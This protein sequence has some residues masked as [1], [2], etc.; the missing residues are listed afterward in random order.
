MSSR[1]RTSYQKGHSSSSVSSSSSP[2]SLSPSSARSPSSSR[3]YNDN[4]SVVSGYSSLSVT[5]S[6]RHAHLPF[7][8]TTPTAPKPVLL[9]DDKHT[10]K[11]RGSVGMMIVGLSGATGCSLLASVVANRNKIQWRG[12]R[13]EWRS[14]N[15]NGCL[16]QINQRGKHGGVGYKDKIGNLANASM[17]AIGGWDIQTRKP[18]DSLLQAH[19]LDYDLVRQVKDDMNKIK[20]FRGIYDPRF[21]NSSYYDKAAHILSVDEVPN[22]SEALKCLR[23]DIRYFK[24]RNGVIGHTSIIWCASIEPDCA[25]LE[26]FKTARD[27]LKAIE[28][29]EEERGGPM[30]PSILYATAALLEGCS[31]I[32]GGNQN[33]LSCAGLSDLAIQLRGVFCLGTGF[34][35]GISRH[36]VAAVEYLRS[37]GLTP[38][39]VA[40]SDYSGKIDTKN[41][42]TQS[43]GADANANKSN[44][45]D[46]FGTWEE[47]IDHKS[48]KT[49]TPF[50]HDKRGF[51]ECTSLGFL[52]QTHTMVTYTQASDS[53]MNVPS[54]IDAA[55]WCDF[56]SKTSW[57]FEK[58]TRALAYLF[59]VPEGAAKEID[60]GFHRQM[61]ELNL[62]AISAR[63]SKALKH[64]KRVRIRPE[65]KTAEWAIPHDARIICAG[66]ACVDMQLNHAS[67]GN[68]NEGIETFE[69]ER[70]IAGG[71][72]S[73]ACKTLAR[74]CHGQPLDGDFM[75][76]TPPVVHSVIPICKVGNDDT[77]NKLISLLEDFGSL[78][79][80]VETK[81]IKLA[82]ARQQSARTAL[83]ILPIFQ[84]GRRGCFFDAASNTTFSAKEIVGILNSLSSGSTGPD[85]NTSHM[86]MGDLEK[87]RERIE[88]M[89]PAYGAFLFGYPHLLPCIQGDAL[90]Q[91][92]LEARINMIEG[93]LVA[94][95][96]NGVPAS[97]FQRSRSLRSVA[98][99]RNDPVIGKGLE[100]IDILHMNEDELMLLTGCQLK[101]TPEADLEDAYAIANAS[102]L[103]LMC[104][105]A[106]VAVTRGEKG[107]F[108][109]CNDTER[110]KR[111]RML[112]FSWA[113]CTAK[114]SAIALPPG[115]V[116]NSNGAGDSFT[117]GLLVAAML[118][119][120]GMTV[121]L[122]PNG[123]KNDNSVTND[124]FS[125]PQKKAPY[126]KKVTP[127]TLYMRENY[128]TLKKQCNDDKKA[129]FSK[130]HEMWENESE[131]VK[132]MYERK[133]QEEN[134]AED[135]NEM[136]L[137]VM[138]AMETLDS[139]KEGLHHNQNSTTHEYNSN[140]R[141]VNDDD[142]TTPHNK[143]MANRSLNLETAVLFAS[144]VSAYHI[145]VRTRNRKHIDMSILLERSM[146]FPTGLE[147]I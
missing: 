122:Q 123:S 5:S 127:Y 64:K 56:F 57:P 116:I 67:G 63:D 21:I 30:P 90:S 62:Q 66:L 124:K 95:D 82:R 14:P 78:C 81:Y 120:T 45:H 60:P 114:G 145:D 118:R 103:F 52:S 140:E 15:Y 9:T 129:I 65:E 89:T 79:R 101:K 146:I 99:L 68:G 61:D 54:I 50:I 107:S 109:S 119:H 71:S 98:C 33:T 97:N 121:P 135:E 77:G 137:S 59:E 147:E 20:V 76:I 139:T 2:S 117:A 13:G 43:I 34:K 12:P 40:S 128:V 141:S 126:E 100:H 87:Y 23:A 143:Y 96:L 86:S 74:L 88:A 37:M 75:Q 47:T 130:C 55:V 102:K 46:I 8:P 25:L 39:V 106:V 44:N 7:A 49:S 32:N 36:K 18:G 51:V 19:I 83:A 26:K 72:V 91:V 29:T 10:P 4:S 142:D 132:S 1:H 134:E 105:V 93:G 70:S 69:G 136:S 42:S 84:D 108:V 92:L 27:L 104:G 38:K 111:T 24:W 115:T 11:T 48:I 53:L 31:F 131:E 17:A 80:N 85:L 110:F 138:D 22:D 35:T 16:T 133:V 73:M 94:M 28:L 125:S 144:L 41:A 112:P 58:V 113:G 6:Y 3:Q